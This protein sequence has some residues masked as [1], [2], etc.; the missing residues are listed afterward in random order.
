MGPNSESMHNHFKC[1]AGID[2]TVIAPD[3]KVYPCFFLA[4]PGYEIGYFD[5][6]KII[7]TNPIEHDGSECIS[8]KILNKNMKSNYYKK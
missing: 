3:S 4:K 6:E 2:Q 1:I 8:Y 7:I 5:G